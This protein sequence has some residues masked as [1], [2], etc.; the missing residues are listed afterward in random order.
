MCEIKT[1]FDYLSPIVQIT[2]H[3]FVK[4]YIQFVNNNKDKAMNCSTNRTPYDK[5]TTSGQNQRMLLIFVE[6][7]FSCL[8]VYL[9]VHVQK[10]L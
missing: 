6:Q 9:Q 4:L 8:T 5:Q 2:V 3:F 10:M 1:C 7:E